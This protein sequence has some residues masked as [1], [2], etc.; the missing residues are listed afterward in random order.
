LLTDLDSDQFEVRGRARQEL[1]KLGELA[2]P[3]L[4]KAL[5]DSASAEVRRTA[6]QLLERLEGARF[7]PPAEELRSLRAVQALEQIGTREAREVLRALAGGAPETRLTREAKAS[8]E[9]LA[10]Q[11]AASP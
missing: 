10:K 1:E 7:N 6:E 2:E 9:R 4:R 3:A 11:S 8:M 5:A